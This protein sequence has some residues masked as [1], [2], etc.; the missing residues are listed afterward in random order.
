MIAAWMLYCSTVALL[1]V[2]AAVPVE[3]FVYERGGGTRRVWSIALLGALL[4]P[5]VAVVIKD[6]PPA[7][8]IGNE[9]VT[10]SATGAVVMN[11]VG[12]MA[13]MD[14]LLATAW[15]VASLGLL[16]LLAAAVLVTAWRRRGWE[17]QD[18]D[19]VS[20]LVS[21]DVGPA[22]IGFLRGRVVLP[23]WVLELGEAERAM[24]LRHEE[25]HLR[26]GD[27]RLIALGTLIVIAM[28]WNLAAWFMLRRLRLA[29]EVD[30]DRRVVRAGGLDMRR[31]AELL[32][33]VGARRSVP[34]YGV[35]FSVGRPFLEQRIDRMTSP[36]SERRRAHALVVA[37][38]VLGVLAATWSLPQPI[39]ASS[40]SSTFEWCPDDS[41]EV[42]RELLTA[43]DWSS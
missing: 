37:I 18:V 28:P 9:I 29:I 32:L 39:R 35:G 16:G 40:I 5:I 25:E 10:T 24:M 33:S 23:R 15:A 12:R 8:E 43:L 4:L 17:R 7:I 36:I 20:V 19:G 38:G 14:G 30:C 2:C 21:R 6:A 22:V 11:S 34:A 3:R 41:S 13:T 42:S 1:L 31:Y 27:P 26:A